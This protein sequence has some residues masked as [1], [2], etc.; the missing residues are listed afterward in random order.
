MNMGNRAIVAYERQDGTYSVHYSHYGAADF[1]LVQT[2]AERTP[3]GE[4]SNAVWA[5]ETIN[6]IRE[7]DVQP[8]TSPLNEEHQA[9][10]EVEPVTRVTSDSLEEL[11][12]SIINYLYY[13]AIYIVDLNW[14]VQIWI[15]MWPGLNYHCRSIGDAAVVGNGALVEHSD[16][17]AIS[18]DYRALTSKWTAA[19]D[20]LGDGLDRNW[21]DAEEASIYLQSKLREWVHPDFTVRFSEEW[22]VGTTR[23]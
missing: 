5:S 7:N 11:V 1:R 2:I 16:S 9:T 22:T 19:K 14:S 20:I 18:T 15:P 21:L 17:T 13:E 8:N 10:P 3:F 12:D 6:E 23:E 4:G